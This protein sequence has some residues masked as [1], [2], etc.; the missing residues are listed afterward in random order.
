M[1]VECV[2]LTDESADADVEKN[3]LASQG[4][5]AGSL[6]GDA[7]TRGKAAAATSNVSE[8]DVMIDEH[9]STPRPGAT[10]THYKAIKTTP[11]G[12]ARESANSA[13]PEYV[14][15]MQSGVSSSPSKLAAIIAASKEKRQPASA[16]ST[17]EKYSS[18]KRETA[19]LNS[20]F[21]SAPAGV[22]KNPTCELG[23]LDN[24][25]DQD[26]EQTS[27]VKRLCRE[28]MQQEGFMD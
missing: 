8:C 28:Q 24:D 10:K 3:S 14:A 1:E 22:A 9:A 2:D 12:A 20:F 16:N 6:D 4:V 23:F 17:I 7:A 27:H 13:D 18:S 26:F 21:K 11:I 15:R 5:D 19:P 25:A